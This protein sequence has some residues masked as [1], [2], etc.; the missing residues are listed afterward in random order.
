MALYQLQVSMEVSRESD[1]TPL[2]RSLNEPVTQKFVYVGLF[3][4]N[5]RP[6]KDLQYFAEAT[7]NAVDL[8]KSLCYNLS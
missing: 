8:R 6:K 1:I 5:N 2:I 7:I 3:N 4:I